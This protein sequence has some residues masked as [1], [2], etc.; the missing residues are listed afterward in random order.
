L[1]RRIKAEDFGEKFNQ[2]NFAKTVRIRIN[3]KKSQLRLIEE[4]KDWTNWKR[5]NG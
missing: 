3:L 4:E 1:W 5:L 2:N